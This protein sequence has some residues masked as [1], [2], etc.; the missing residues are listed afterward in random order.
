MDVREAEPLDSPGGAE[1]RELPGEETP[2]R[3]VEDGEETEGSEEN[4]EK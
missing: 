3:S 2:R 4:I 1:T